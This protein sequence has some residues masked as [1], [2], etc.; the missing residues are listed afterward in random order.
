MYSREAEN[1]TGMWLYTI[2]FVALVVL[3]QLSKLAAFTSLRI[4]GPVRLIPDIF[5]LHYLE[6]TGAAFGILRD[7][8]WLFVVF[9]GVIMVLLFLLERRMVH[10]GAKFRPLALICAMIAAGAAGNMI[11][12]IFHG[13]VIDFLYFRLIDFPVFNV[14]DIY[15]VVGCIL[16]VILI[17]FIYKDDDLAALSGKKTRADYIADIA[18]KVNT[19]RK[20][21]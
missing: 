8:Q 2:F 17:S 3:D 14:A 11:D 16:L 20:D 12:R 13:Y 18:E 1:K 19:S 6:N 10:A 9:A 15:V 21:D 7:Q 4:N 5:E